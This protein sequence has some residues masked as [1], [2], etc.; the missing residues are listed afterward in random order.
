MKIVTSVNTPNQK[1]KLLRI[2]KNIEAH[3]H[4]QTEGKTLDIY[5]CLSFQQRF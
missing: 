5:D 3:T 1:G 2:D 4:C